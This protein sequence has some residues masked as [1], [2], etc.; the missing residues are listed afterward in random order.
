MICLVELEMRLIDM[1]IGQWELG[2][3]ESFV[4]FVSLSMRFII[5]EIDIE[6]HT[7][8]AVCVSE[9]RNHKMGH[10]D[11]HPFGIGGQSQNIS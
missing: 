1:V 5:H 7:Q 9:K 2:L 6:L 4:V 10:L 11:Y 8:G 3:M